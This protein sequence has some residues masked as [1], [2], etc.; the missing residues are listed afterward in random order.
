[1]A[2]NN[3]YPHVP[4]WHTNSVSFC[5]TDYNGTAQIAGFIVRYA[6]PDSELFRLGI[7]IGKGSRESFILSKIPWACIP[8]PAISE[9]YKANQ[10]IAEYECEFI[11]N[12]QLDDGA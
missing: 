7:R 5:H 8:A 12:T 1:M 3:D 11:V 6:E 9:Y 4:W 10:D 2:R